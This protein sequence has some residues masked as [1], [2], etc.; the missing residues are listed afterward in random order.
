MFRGEPENVGGKTTISLA[1]R[2]SFLE[3]E[4]GFQ[5]AQL[6]LDNYWLLFGLDCAGYNPN[7][8]Q[9]L[10]RHQPQNVKKVYLLNAKQKIFQKLLSDKHNTLTE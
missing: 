5:H 3:F 8:D 6:S 1:R 7:V 9:L 10:H 4:L 2:F